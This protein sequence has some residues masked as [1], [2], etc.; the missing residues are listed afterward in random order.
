[1]TLRYSY[2]KPPVVSL[3]II[4]TSCG[5]GFHFWVYDQQLFTRTCTR[6]RPKTPTI[7]VLVVEPS[8]APYPATIP[9]TLEAMQTLVGG[10][11]TVFETGVAGTVGIANDEALLQQLPPNRYIEA[12]GAVIS[13]TFFVAGDGLSFHSLSEK[14]MEAA[15]RAF[16]RPVTMEQIREALEREKAA[17]EELESEG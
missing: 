9:N 4:T 15:K 5:V 7:S 14:E 3:T 1:M 6:A 13:G 2:G 12:T 8:Q 11:I 16:E 10:L 17:R